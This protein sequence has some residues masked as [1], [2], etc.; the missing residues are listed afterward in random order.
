MSTSCSI[1]FIWYAR[2][3]T[4]R[5][6]KA[7]LENHGVRVQVRDIISQTPTAREL[8]AWY[9]ASGY[10]SARR[11]CNTSGVSYREDHIKDLLDKGMTNDELFLRME[12]NGKLIKR[13]LL[14]GTNAQTGEVNFVCA[15][16]KEDEWMRALEL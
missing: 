2:C 9:E 12:Q 14:I 11:L 6:A 13:P 8:A 10:S 16:F 3:S 15:G 4:C 1:E 5:K 7:W